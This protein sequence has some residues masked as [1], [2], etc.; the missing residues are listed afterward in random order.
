MTRLRFRD[1]REFHLQVLRIVLVMAAGAAVSVLAGGGRLAATLAGAVLVPALGFAI[2]PPTAARRAADL[3]GALAGAGAGALI[4]LGAPT[5]P[6]LTAAA[7]GMAAALLGSRSQVPVRRV[8]VTA[9][10]GLAFALAAFVGAT[11]GTIE[12][13]CDLPPLVG[14]SV[15]GAAAGLT[16]ALGV[17]GLHLS[18]ER[19]AVLEAYAGLKDALE[20]EVGA[21][22]DQSLIAYRRIGPALDGL[23]PEER[24]QLRKA[25]SDLVLSILHLARRLVAIDREAHATSAEELSRRVDALDERIA[26]TDDAVA[27]EQYRLART[28]VLAQLSYLKDIGAGRERIIARMHHD[29]AGLER[30]RLALVNHRSADV[31]RL[32]AEVQLILEDLRSLGQE[33]DLKAEA[34]GE[35]QATIDP[36][37]DPA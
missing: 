32:S 4:G 17:V 30:L 21:I 24:G 3:L 36:A 27:R 14:Q 11:L 19:D 37:A 6:Y 13:L 18:V 12:P 10:S 22:V 5:A 34:M 35:A 29:L 23:G 25:T 9:A 7:L 31:Q 2:A 15:A 28:A 16:A 33:Y 8:I 1:H 20:G 26:R